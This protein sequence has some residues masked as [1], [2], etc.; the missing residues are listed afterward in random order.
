MGAEQALTAISTRK[1]GIPQTLK[2]L[3]PTFKI[4]AF[5]LRLS[6]VGLSTCKAGCTVAA[7]KRDRW[8]H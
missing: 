2:S 1:P 7:G 6:K 3:R 4:G 8:G 5:W